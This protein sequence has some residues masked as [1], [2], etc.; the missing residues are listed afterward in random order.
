MLD[1][2]TEVSQAC[3]ILG[4]NWKAN[5]EH[6]VR[7]IK[8]CWLPH[9]E[10]D[11][12]TWMAISECPHWSGEIEKI[13]AAVLSRFSISI[14]SMSY[15]AMILAANQTDVALRLVRAKLDFLLAEAK[16][17]PEPPRFPEEGTEEEKT[18]WYIRY[19]PT[20]TI[21]G[22]LDESEW[23]DLPSLSEVAPTAFLQILWP[24]YVTVFTEILTRKDRE[25]F[26]HIYPGQY[27]LEIDLTP[28]ETRSAFRE[29]PVMSAIQIAV[30]ELSEKSPKDF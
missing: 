30:E 2:D 26:K 8:E 18:S 13:A 4:I 16:D 1:T 6:V 27:I 25:G 29:T 20:K 12:Y 15:T 17:S 7:L 11:I 24:W 5:G 22:L 9:P 19:D 14:G 21:K 23:H 28:S 3:R 10:R